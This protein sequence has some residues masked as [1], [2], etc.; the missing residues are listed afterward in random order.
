[1]AFLSC[2][3][4]AASSDGRGITLICCDTINEVARIQQE[5]GYPL[6]IIKQF[7]TVEEYTV[8]K[9]AGLQAEMIGGKLSLVRTD[10]DL[11]TVLDEYGQNNFVRL[12]KVLTRLM[13]QEK[14]LSGTIL[15][16]TMMQL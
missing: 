13:Q 6:S 8:F 14:C 2:R 3:R 5:S 11:Y 9:N 12:K 1:M 10:I 15:V 7:H 16:K 4:T